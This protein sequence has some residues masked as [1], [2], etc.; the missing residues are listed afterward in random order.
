M[1]NWPALEADFRNFLL[2]SEIC[3]QPVQ[4]LGMESR[5]MDNPLADVFLNFSERDAA[6][7]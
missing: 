2:N 6:I 5:R 4:Q 3:E 7:P 1:S